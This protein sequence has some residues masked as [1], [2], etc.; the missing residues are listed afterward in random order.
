MDT[1][2]TV[3][4]GG[5]FPPL[6]FFC[7]IAFS[8]EILRTLNDFFFFGSPNEI[9]TSEP[10]VLSGTKSLRHNMAKGIGFCLI[11]RLKLL[12]D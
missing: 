5:D 6:I 12:N 1:A 2:F 9:C 11:K 8:L 7:V 4:G 3:G 10:A